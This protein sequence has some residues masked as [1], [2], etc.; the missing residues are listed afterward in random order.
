MSFKITGKEH[1]ELLLYIAIDLFKKKGA[2]LYGKNFKPKTSKTNP[3]S[4]GIW[5]IVTPH[6]FKLRRKHQFDVLE[7]GHMESSALT[8][9]NTTSKR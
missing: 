7:L 1:V 2:T 8:V 4:G 5:A 6:A 3:L 9:T